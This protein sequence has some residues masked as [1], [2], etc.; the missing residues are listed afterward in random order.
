[1]LAARPTPRIA[2]SDEYFISRNLYPNVDFYSGLIYKAIGFPAVRRVAAGCIACRPRRLTLPRQRLVS[3]SCRRTCFPCC[4]SSRAPLAGWHTGPSSSESRTSK[5]TGRTWYARR[6][7]ARSRSGLGLTGGGRDL[8]RRH[9]GGRQL[10]AGPG[11]R[12]YVPIAERAPANVRTLDAPE[13]RL[14][15]RRDI[16]NSHAAAGATSSA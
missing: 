13:S 3:A 1:M 9:V 10:Y 5:C 2:L 14:Q 16:S 15:I 7:W 6:A 11:P 12:P 8:A 4:S